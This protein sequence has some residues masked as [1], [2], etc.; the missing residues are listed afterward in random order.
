MQKFE[1]VI[2]I[3]TYGTD[4]YEAGEKAGRFLSDHLV[5][6]EEFYISCESTTPY[7]AAQERAMATV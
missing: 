5:S 4:M 7:E 1:T 6:N 3:V 2:H